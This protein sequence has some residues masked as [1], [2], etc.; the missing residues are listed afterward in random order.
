LE[1][2]DEQTVSQFVSQLLAV[3]GVVEVT[4]HN[5]EK[6]AYLKIDSQQLNKEQLQNLIDEY[7][8]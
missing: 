3:T 4:I 5:E 1:N 7:T 2:L 8:N 6:V